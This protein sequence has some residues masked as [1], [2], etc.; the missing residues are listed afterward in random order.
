MSG[1]ALGLVGLGHIGCSIARGLREAGAVR[2]VFGHDADAE[3]GELARALG[4]VDAV[5]ADPSA[6]AAHA[7]LL[8]LAVPPS[9]IAPL[10]ARLQ[11][12][13][14]PQHVVTDVGSIK[15]QVLRDVRAQLG[16]APA[17]FVPGHP[18]A[19]TEKQ[20]PRAASG[21]LFR[22]RH[23]VLTPEAGTGDA[24]VAR[25]QEMWKRL[26]ARVALLDADAHDRLLAGLSHLPHVLSYA[27]IEVLAER[28][29]LEEIRRYSAGGLLDFTRIASSSPELWTDICR[30]NRAQLAAVLDHYRAHLEELAGALRADRPETLHASFAAAKRARDRLRGADS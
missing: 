19:G 8:V 1:D 3:T 5:H 7:E 17:W 10:C 6:L 13:L 30:G 18:I 21:E 4:I 25:V 16:E 9:A 27:L 2:A 12:A 15:G 24:A 26:G 23:V 20:G 29:P 14:G 11:P 22:D 28:F